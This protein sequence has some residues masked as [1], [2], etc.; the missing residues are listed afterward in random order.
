MTGSNTGFIIYEPYFSGETVPD[1]SLKKPLPDLKQIS[2]EICDG[3]GDFDFKKLNARG[4]C[5]YAY[6]LAKG[7]LSVSLRCPIAVFI[8]G[9]NVYSDNFGIFSCCIDEES[10]LLI[11][12]IKRAMNGIFARKSTENSETNLF[13]ITTGCGSRTKSFFRTFI[14]RIQIFRIVSRGAEETAGWRL[15]LRK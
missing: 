7:K 2:P 13:P 1:A 3:M 8:N 12:C 4:Y 9:E 14:F 5:S 10:K 11:K 6:V 15:R